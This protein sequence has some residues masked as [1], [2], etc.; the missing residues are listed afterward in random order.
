MDSTLNLIN[1]YFKDRN[2]KVYYGNNIPSHH[3]ELYVKFDAIT[4]NDEFALE[5][6][7]KLFKEEFDKYSNEFFERIKIKSINF[8]KNLKVDNSNSKRYIPISTTP[9]PETSSLIVDIDHPSKNDLYNRQCIHH[10][11]FHLIDF[12]LNGTFVFQDLGWLDLNPKNFTYGNGGWTAY[13]DK[14]F[15]NIQHPKD[16]FVSEYATLSIDEDRA[17]T[18]MYTMTD[19]LKD[20]LKQWMLEDKIL[21]EKVKYLKEWL[22]F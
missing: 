8:V 19:H 20:Y 22:N 9:D 13:F 18:W 14:N 6:Y 5:K 4:H 10:E 1:A 15:K 3:Q 16:G 12:N 17:E 7:F 21:E 2:L 11:L